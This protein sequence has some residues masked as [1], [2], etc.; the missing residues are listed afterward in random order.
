[1][2]IS[3]K[4]GDKVIVY[5]IHE[6]HEEHIFDGDKFITIPECRK[7]KIKTSD[8][9]IIETTEQDKLTITKA[10]KL[11][12]DAIE[13]LIASKVIPELPTEESGD[14]Q[15]AMWLNMAG[16]RIRAHLQM[17]GAIM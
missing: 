4:I 5:D 16:P 10:K 9:F 2:S 14:G 12:N 11:V 3:W 8:N 6:F 1:M 17:T 13:E 15:K 7:L